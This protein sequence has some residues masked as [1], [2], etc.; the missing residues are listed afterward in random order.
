MLSPSVGSALKIDLSSRLEAS[1]HVQLYLMS[2]KDENLR[3][4]S[5]LKLDQRR[6]DMWTMMN[7]HLHF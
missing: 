7:S 6:G 5:K 3:K 2:T 1:Y 4:K